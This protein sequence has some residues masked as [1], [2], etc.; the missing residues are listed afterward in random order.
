MIADI[1]IVHKLQV[2]II[3]YF[4]YHNDNKI[5]TNQKTHKHLPI[6]LL[7]RSKKV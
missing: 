4:A 7:Q 6:K 2:H 3:F 5:E 1:S